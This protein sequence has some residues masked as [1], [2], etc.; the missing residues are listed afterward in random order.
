MNGTKILTIGFG[1]FSTIT[2]KTGAFFLPKES[3]GWVG[4]LILQ[5]QN[6]YWPF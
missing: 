3:N 4:L 5:T 6:Q 2:K 1:E